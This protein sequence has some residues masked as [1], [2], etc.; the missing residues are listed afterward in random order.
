MR[1]LLLFFVA[2]GLVGTAAAGCCHVH[3]VCDA[4]ILTPC[5]TR[6]PWV[7]QV[8]MPVEVKDAPKGDGKKL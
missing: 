3:G 4:Y 7:E 8:V 2:L 5:A 6:Q 1:R